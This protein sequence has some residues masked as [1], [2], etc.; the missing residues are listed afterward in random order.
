MGK[1]RLRR[2]IAWMNVAKVLAR[3]LRA[4]SSFSQPAPTTTMKR[5]FKPYS[6]QRKHMKKNI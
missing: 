2:E 5:I 4:H 6:F 3:P 1:L